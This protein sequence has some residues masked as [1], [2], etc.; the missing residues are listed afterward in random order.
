MA[1]EEFLPQVVEMPHPVGVKFQSFE[2]AF[3]IALRE[4]VP[5]LRECQ[6]QHFRS[7][8]HYVEFV[9]VSLG[10]AFEKLGPDIG[11]LRVGVRHVGQGSPP[12]MSFQTRV[13]A[14]YR[15]DSR[16]GGLDIDAVGEHPER[17]LNARIVLAYVAVGQCFDP[18]PVALAQI[19]G[20]VQYILVEPLAYAKPFECAAQALE[21]VPAVFEDVADPPAERMEIA[22]QVGV[23]SEI[24]QEA[25]IVRLAVEVVV[26]L[27]DLR[28]VTEIVE[29]SDF[30]LRNGFEVCLHVLLLPVFLVVIEHPA[31]L[32]PYGLRVCSLQCLVYVMR[33]PGE[34][35]RVPVVAF[36]VLEEIHFVEDVKSVDVAGPVHFFLLR[37]ECLLDFSE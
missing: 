16:I 36:Y 15:A 29:H 30:A 6:F 31:Y 4:G 33:D 13:Y 11:D 14:G 7:Y 27:V 9:P 37:K 8:V 10:G 22:G 32:K 3:V 35:L 28:F 20:A 5:F 21:V 23:A 26:D 2:I 12:P 17:F 25:E 1:G 24:A 18:L 19:P 34:N